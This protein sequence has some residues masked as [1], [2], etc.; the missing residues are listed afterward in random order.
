M[1]LFYAQASPFVRK[2]M[3][4][5]HETGQVD[6]VELL[7][8]MVTTTMPSDALIAKNPLSKLPAL[9]RDDGPAIYDSRVICAYLDDRA[10]AG[11][12]PS[13]PSYWEHLTLEATADGI[14]DAGVLM[15]YEGRV[16]PEEKQWSGWVDAQWDK[17]ARALTAVNERWMG[18]LAGPLTMSQIAIGCALGYMDFRHADRNWREGNDALAE[19]Y[20]TFE[21]RPSMQATLPPVG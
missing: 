18:H 5:L 9:D 12:Y 14:M 3:V 6:D 13:G 15:V 1:K 7:D 8:T 2:V 10:K 11:L 17:A 4:T 16:R 19:W 21:S 20:A